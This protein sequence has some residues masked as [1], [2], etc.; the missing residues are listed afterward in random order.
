MQPS[1]NHPDLLM[2]RTN[3][4]PRKNILPVQNSRMMMKIILISMPKDCPFG[5]GI[6]IHAV[7]MQHA[8]LRCKQYWNSGIWLMFF[9]KMRMDSSAS[10]MLCTI[11]SIIGLGLKD[12]GRIGI[13]G[14]CRARAIQCD[15][16][17]KP[18]GSR[19]LMIRVFRRA[20][21]IWYRKIFVISVSSENTHAI[22]MHVQ[23]FLRKW[24]SS[25]LS[26]FISMVLGRGTQICRVSGVGWYASSC[27]SY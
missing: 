26:Q 15:D 10:S 20:G 8:W 19:L 7:S 5:N 23:T 12:N 3:L 22:R 9:G 4:S 24:K 27:I 14:Q 2:K 16:I 18:A 6:R 25:H 13:N 11:M 17:S 21:F 1:L